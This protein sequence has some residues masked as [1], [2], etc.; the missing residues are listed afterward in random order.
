MM[1][2]RLRGAQT[3]VS[4]AAMDHHQTLGPS[5]MSGTGGQTCTQ[6]GFQRAIH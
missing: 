5:P 6:C 1:N 3:L 4:T 2:N